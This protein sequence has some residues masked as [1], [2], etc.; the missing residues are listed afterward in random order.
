[1]AREVVEGDYIINSRRFEIEHAVKLIATQQPMASDL[2]AHHR[3][4]P[5]RHRN[6]A[7]R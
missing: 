7:Y 1:M 2:R 4:H 6:R 3:R 5:H